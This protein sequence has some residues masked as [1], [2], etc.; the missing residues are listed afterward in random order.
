MAKKP[1]SD[2]LVIY[3]RMLRTM[4]SVLTGDMKTL[5]HEALGDG[6]LNVKASAEDGSDAYMQEL[7]LDLLQRDERTVGEVMD[8]L[9]RVQEGTFAKCGVCKKWVRKTRMMAMPHARNCID[10]QR[11]EESGA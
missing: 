5:E 6:A 9:D 10:C 1:T 11:A 8:A 2:E 7:N 3:E 4:L